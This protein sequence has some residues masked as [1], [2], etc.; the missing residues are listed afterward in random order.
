M[1]IDHDLIDFYNEHPEKVPVPAYLSLALPMSKADLASGALGHFMMELST[2]Q[3]FREMSPERLQEC[4]ATGFGYP[5]WSSLLALDATMADT[6]QLPHTSVQLIDAVAWRMYVGGFTG[7]C[8][9]MVALQ[10]SWSGNTLQ[11]KR[12]YINNRIRK[13]EEIATTVNFSRRHVPGLETNWTQWDDASLTEDGLVRVKFAAEMA[14]EV[15]QRCWTPNCGVSVEQLNAH[16][17]QG[18]HMPVET[19]IDRSWYFSEPWPTGLSPIQFMHADG[20]LA[21]FG[22]YWGE[23]GLMHCSV[24]ATPADFKKSAVALWHRQP[25]GDFA[26]KSL[27]EKLVQVAFENPWDPRDLDSETP[28]DMK[29]IIAYESRF[30]PGP[31]MDLIPTKDH[32]ISLGLGITLDNEPWT[33]PE[34][35]LDPSDLEGVL[36]LQLPPLSEA[37]EEVGEDTQWLQEKVPYALDQQTF[38]TLMR[39]RVAVYKGEQEQSQWHRSNDSQSV[40]SRL[41]KLSAT[42]ANPVPARDA[43]STMA[44]PFVQACDVREAGE[45]IPRI[46]PELAPLPEE[47]RGEYAIAFYGKNGVR[48]DRRHLRRDEE[49]MLYAIVRNLGADPNTFFRGT[50]AA[51]FNLVRQA[52]EGVGESAWTDPVLRAKLSDQTRHLSAKIRVMDDLFD[53]LDHSL[54]AS[55]LALIQPQ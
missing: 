52:T 33:R 50:I 44:D 6:Q 1:P 41:L 14:H 43:E 29:A 51:L 2:N 19:L 8:D 13:G 28:N 5:S 20:G 48:H 22:W 11:L 54:S 4:V 9:A 46:Y 35:S 32:R 49:F 45:E 30:A 36:G 39:L 42:M 55:R 15:A 23:I 53:N 31:W 47:M 37:M 34:N 25:I 24:F 16:I 21:G 3:G 27:P 12:Q 10:G 17:E 26:L 38:D 18:A 7:L 40:L